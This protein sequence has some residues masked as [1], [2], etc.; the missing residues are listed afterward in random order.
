MSASGQ[1]NKETKLCLSQILLRTTSSPN[2]KPQQQIT[3][4]DKL[5]ENILLW[6]KKGAPIAPLKILH[7]SLGNKI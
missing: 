1:K 6:A 7:L 3:H 5:F 2:C 4:A